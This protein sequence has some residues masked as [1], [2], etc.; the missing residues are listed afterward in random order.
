MSYIAPL[1]LFKVQVRTL[2]GVWQDATAAIPL[3]TAQAV[4]GYYVAGTTV[5]FLYVGKG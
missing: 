1:S 3:K 4:A 2:A 5:R